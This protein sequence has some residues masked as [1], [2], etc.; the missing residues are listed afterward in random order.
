MRTLSRTG[1]AAW[2]LQVTASNLLRTCG[3]D[4]IPARRT[5]SADRIV[6]HWLRV[7]AWRLFGPDGDTVV[8]TPLGRFFLSDGVTP[9]SGPQ[10]AGRHDHEVSR[11]VTGLLRPGMTVVDVGANVGYFS[12]PAAEKVGRSG[13]VVAIEPIEA[14]VELL[15]RNIALN[16]ADQIQVVHAAAVSRPGPVTMHRSSFTNA[17]GSLLRNACATGEP[18]EVPGTTLD[19]VAEQLSLDRI[20]LVKIDAEG[21]DLDVLLGAG[22]VL[23]RLR[24]RLVVE[25]WP[26]GLRRLGRD[27]YLLFELAAEH[28]YQITAHRRGEPVVLSEDPEVFRSYVDQ[29]DDRNYGYSNV[30]LVPRG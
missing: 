15:H 29:L 9:P 27:P 21:A 20:D 22:Q 23:A 2:R 14:N 8:D 19:T 6:E 5:S 17:R 1:H 12:I 26:R 7:A 3:L 11:W 28:R 30:L 16:A 10:I 18:V 4:H 24:P 25:F 13:R